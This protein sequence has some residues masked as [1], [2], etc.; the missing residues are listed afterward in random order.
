MHESIAIAR[1]A[2]TFL[3]LVTKE[4]APSYKHYCQD[5][6]MEKVRSKKREICPL[7]TIPFP[8]CLMSNYI[9]VYYEHYHFS[10]LT[11]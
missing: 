9:I 6:L 11:N 3:F 7:N 1:C 10:Y 2:A 5:P 8:P 4:R